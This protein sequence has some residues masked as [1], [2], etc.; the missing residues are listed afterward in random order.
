[1]QAKSEPKSRVAT[2]IVRTAHERALW[3]ARTEV[4]NTSQNSSDNLPTYP[5]DRQ[6]LQ[7]RCCLFD[8]MGYIKSEIDH[9]PT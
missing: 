1:M 7:F 6:S 2:L 8:G 4:H 3:L 9:K 5:P